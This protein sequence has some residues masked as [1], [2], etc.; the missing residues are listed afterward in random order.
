MFAALLLFLPALAGAQ[1][2]ETLHGE[3][4]E[5]RSNRVYGCYCEWSGEGQTGGK[6]AVLG[7]H[8]RGGQYRGEDLAG[9][10]MAAVIVGEGSLSMGQAPRKSLLF[11]DRQASAG[12]RK[13]AEALLRSRFA[14]LLGKVLGVHFEPIEFQRE[15]E[16]ARLRIGG[17]VNVEMRKARLPEDALQGSVLWYDPFLPLA[18]SHLG[19]VLNTRYSGGEFNHRWASSDPGV[20]G[21]FGTFVLRTP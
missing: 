7:W 8:I 6:E 10:R 20:N 21:Y 2:G 19:T 13:A 16:R 17:H 3:Y 18:E 15:P 5:D 11:V 12:Q 1:P 14:A 4:I 9:V